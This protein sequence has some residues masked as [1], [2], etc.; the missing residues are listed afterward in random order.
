M[1]RVETIMP[2]RRAF[3]PLLLSLGISK[4][5]EKKLSSKVGS[6]IKDRNGDPF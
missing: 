5:E 2:F 1:K 6:D 4:S 3:H